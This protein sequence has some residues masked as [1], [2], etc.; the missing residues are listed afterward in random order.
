M[1]AR[2]A[3]LA[4]LVIFLYGCQPEATAPSDVTPASQTRPEAAEPGGDAMQLAQKSTCLA[5]H[6]LDKKVVGPSFREI[7]AKYRDDPGAEARLMD[8]IAKGSRGTWGAAVMPPLPQVSEENR[9]VLV[10][11]VLS[12]K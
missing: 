3:L 12:Q 11:F 8:V 9:H 7:A 6:A 2:N 10:K 4:S 5:C 1:H